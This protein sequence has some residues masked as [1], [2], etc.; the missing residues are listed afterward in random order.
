MSKWSYEL[1]KENVAVLAHN[2]KKKEP[3]IMTVGGI[4]GFVATAVLAY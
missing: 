3:L 1:F 2:Y 4:A